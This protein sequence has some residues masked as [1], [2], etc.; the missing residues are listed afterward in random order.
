[1]CA[2]DMFWNADVLTCWCVEV[3]MCWGVDMSRVESN[4]LL[5]WYVDRCESFGGSLEEIWVKFRRSLRERNSVEKKFGKSWREVWKNFWEKD[6]SNLGSL[7]FG[8]SL[9]EIWKSFQ[10][11]S[12]LLPSFFQTSSK[13]LQNFFQTWWLDD[14]TWWL[15]DLMTL[16]WWL[17]GLMT[18][19]LDEL[20]T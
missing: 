11:S 7:D 13:L 5:T 17:D 18:W 16:T 10:T 12:K 9:W 14:L 15:G 19:W 20:R 4:R 1:M 3:L 8:R 6:G 2:V